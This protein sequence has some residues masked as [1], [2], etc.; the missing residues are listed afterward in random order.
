MNVS[1]P[2]SVKAKNMPTD[3]AECA[4]RI[5]YVLPQSAAAYAGL[6]SFVPN[7]REPSAGGGV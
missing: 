6:P 3:F 4:D 7:R 1:I 2:F 5:S